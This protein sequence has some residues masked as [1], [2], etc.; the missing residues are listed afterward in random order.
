MQVSWYTV[1]NYTFNYNYSSLFS[2]TSTRGL[3]SSSGLP[4]ANQTLADDF[5]N[6]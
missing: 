2:T 4:A 6:G 1:T 5:I 3:P